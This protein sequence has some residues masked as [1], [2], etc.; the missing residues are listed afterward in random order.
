MIRL[1][2]C[3]MFA[4]VIFND[5]IAYTTVFYVSYFVVLHV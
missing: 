3:I 4:F 1:Q 2:H 5:F